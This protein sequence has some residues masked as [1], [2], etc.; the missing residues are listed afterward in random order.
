VSIHGFTGVTHVLY[1]S[2]VPGR[3]PFSGAENHVFVLLEGL[4]RSGVDVE[5]IAMLWA[6]DEYPIV[7]DK[8]RSLEAAGV[9]VTPVRRAAARSTLGRWCAMGR[10]WT[11]L[12]R[13]LRARRDRAIHLHLDLSMS[14]LIAALAGCRRVLASV[15]NDE[16]IYATLRWRVWWRVVN[17]CVRHFISITHHVARYLE[18]V[19]RLRAQK[20]STVYYGVSPALAEVDARARLGVDPNAFVVGFV[21][22]LTPQKNVIAFVHAMELLPDVVAVIVGTGE[23]RQSLEEAIAQRTLTNVRLVGNIP[24]AR[25]VM[26]GF[27]LFCLPSHWEGLGLVLIEAMLQQVPIVGS[28]RGAIPEILDYGRFGLVFDPTAVGIASAIAAV[29]ARPDV[30]RARAAAAYAHA[31]ELFTVPRMVTETVAVYRAL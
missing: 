8:L 25:T 6:G 19:G 14:V 27:D 17:L 13:L 4:A 30:A 26:S 21:G 11:T 18:R 3:S 15:H 10:S 16:P 2:E 20:I 31:A 1:L 24:D 7:S 5:L 9:R 23:L 22:R 29:R 12:W 28:N